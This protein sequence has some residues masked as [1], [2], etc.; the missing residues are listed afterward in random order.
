MKDIIE[1][2]QTFEDIWGDLA[3]WKQLDPEQQQRL[4][5][6]VQRTYEGQIPLIRRARDRRLATILRGFEDAR[7]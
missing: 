2:V 6:E 3:H 4:I 7:E 5:H 1:A